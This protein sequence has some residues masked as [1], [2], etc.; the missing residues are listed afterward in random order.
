MNVILGTISLILLIMSMVNPASAALDAQ[1]LSA[2]LEI[3]DYF[4]TARDGIPP[5]NDLAKI[6]SDKDIFLEK[7]DH[8]RKTIGSN[9]QDKDKNCKRYLNNYYTVLEELTDLVPKVI[10]TTNFLELNKKDWL[11]LS[12]IEIIS[13]LLGNL[14]LFMN[15]EMEAGVQLF[16]QSESYTCPFEDRAAVLA[17]VNDVND[18]FNNLMYDAF[19]FLGVDDFKLQTQQ[20]YGA[21]VDKEIKDRRNMM[22]SLG[23]GFVLS[24]L[25]WSYAPVFF[26]KATMMTTATVT[27]S[28]ALR[29]SSQVIGL[30]ALG[31]SQRYFNNNILFQ[32]QKLLEEKELG[33]DPW[34]NQLDFT[35]DFLSSRKN[36]PSLYFE[37]LN[38]IKGHMF[39]RMLDLL[40]LWEEDLLAAERKWGSIDQAYFDTKNQLDQLMEK[41]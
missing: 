17:S 8:A 18:S 24:I 19:G 40:K 34:K 27:N 22:V 39:A 3:F 25:V 4:L 37:I 15:E 12:R 33:L 2:R 23:A 29:V 11:N 30:M 6:L 41:P 31:Y 36:S 10:P 28:F 32:E 13:M 20:L 16:N 7:A 35:E 9:I 14:T 26:A 1:V 38:Q 21:M 5:S